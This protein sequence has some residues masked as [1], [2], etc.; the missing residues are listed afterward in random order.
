[1]NKGLFI[2]FEGP[3]GAGKTTQLEMLRTYFENSDLSCIVTREPGGTPMAEQFR[4]LVKHHD[5]DEP[6]FNETELLLFAAS[7]AQHVRY[8]I[9]PALQCGTN[10]LCDRF[11]DSTTAYQGYGRKINLDFIKI[12]NRYAAGECIPDLTIVLDLPPE[13]GLKRVSN[14]EVVNGYDRLEQEEMSFHRMVRNGFL[15][16]AEQEPERV[17]V[18]SALAPPEEI[19]CKIVRLVEDVVEK[20][21]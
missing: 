17:K 9:F 15:K 6:I 4:Q 2:T 7:R 19:H 14:R 10:V 3:E 13:S 8:I 1:M 12:L 21:R 5:E 18:V 11:Y 20:I 16:I